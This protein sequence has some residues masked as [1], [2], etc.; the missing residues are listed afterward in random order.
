[1]FVNECY[2]IELSVLDGTVNRCDRLV[3][4]TSPYPA[5]VGAEDTFPVEQRRAVAILVEGIEIG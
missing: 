3:N 1:M 5:D 2:L 4:T